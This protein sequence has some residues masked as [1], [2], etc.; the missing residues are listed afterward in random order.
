MNASFMGVFWREPGEIA[1]KTGSV[2][3]PTCGWNPKGVWRLR[4][5][6]TSL[7]RFGS[8]SKHYVRYELDCPYENHPCGHNCE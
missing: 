2:S 3:E 8:T 4:M 7:A 1:S 6:A 5:P